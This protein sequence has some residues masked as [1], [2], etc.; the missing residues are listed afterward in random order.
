MDADRKLIDEAGLL[1]RLRDEDFHFSLKGWTGD[2]GCYFGSRTLSESRLPERARWLGDNPKRYSGSLDE[3]GPALEELAQCVRNWAG[4][5]DFHG[6]VGEEAPAGLCLTLGRLVEPDWVILCAEQGFSH[7]VI[8]G[9]VCFPSGWDFEE[10]L[11]EPLTEVHAAVPGLNA[12][13]GERIARLL[14]ALRAGQSWERMNW[15]LALSRE[16]NQHPARHLPKVDAVE[17]FE[18]LYLR[19]EWQSLSRLPESGCVLFGIRPLHV[20]LSELAG[21]GGAGRALFR[22]LATMPA[23]MRRYKG[24]SRH[25]DRIG[26]LLDNEDR[27]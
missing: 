11:G 15:G 3:A 27:W 18:D 21:A 16:L 1:D 12:A 22:Q 13:A 10:T 20:A 24:L 25:L 17:S 5:R 9:C 6:L 8:A 14:T 7:R 26:S 23:E 19:M 4:V 2:P